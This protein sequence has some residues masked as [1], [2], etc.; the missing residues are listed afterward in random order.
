MN[1][2]G[3]NLLRSIVRLGILFVV[4]G[5]GLATTAWLYANASDSMKTG[6]AV[7]FGIL[8]TGVALRYLDHLLARTPRVEA[9]LV[10]KDEL[11]SLAAI[12]ENVTGLHETIV[13]LQESE[14][15]FRAATSA[16][17]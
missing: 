16:M 3:E 11:T 4:A 9:A 2:L 15:R 13:C 1:N 6:L 12:A 10:D 14:G 17:V 8:A 5:I 7:A